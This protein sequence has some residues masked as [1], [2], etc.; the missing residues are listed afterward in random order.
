MSGL[1]K[2]EVRR[3]RTDGRNRQALRRTVRAGPEEETGPRQR[4]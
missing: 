1:R 4:T 3:L 2:Q